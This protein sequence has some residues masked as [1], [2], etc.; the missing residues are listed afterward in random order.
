MVDGMADLAHR[1]AGWVAPLVAVALILGI[2][3][4]LGWMAL[5]LS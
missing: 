1:L 5:E 3:W 4:L 2:P